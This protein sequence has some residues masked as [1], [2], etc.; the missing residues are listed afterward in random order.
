[1]TKAF[2]LWD[3]LRGRRTIADAAPHVSASESDAALVDAFLAG[4][5]DALTVLVDRH[6]PMVYHFVY[7]YVG[8]GDDASDVAQETFIKAW[9][10]I[11]RFDHAKSFKTWI[12]TIA[13]NTALDL[14]KKK[15][16]LPFSKIEE[17]EHDLD[18]F[19]APHIEGPELPD[20]AF[21]RKRSREDVSTMLDTLPAPYRTVL[22]LRYNDHLKFREIAAVLKE[23]I[24]T[25]KSKHRRALLLLRKL[26]S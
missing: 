6:L 8:N 12:L 7:R 25:V 13:R 2:P 18:A 11:H 10:H 14:L 20:V 22:S 26:A 5:D 24:D 23:P 4:S 15:K 21:D 3:S 17:G 19:L 16:A 1:M 9:K